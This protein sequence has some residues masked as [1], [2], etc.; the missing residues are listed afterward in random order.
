MRLYEIIHM[1]N[2]YIKSWSNFVK[3]INKNM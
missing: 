1:I 2:K 3:G